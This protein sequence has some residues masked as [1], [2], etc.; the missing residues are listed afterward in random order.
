MFLGTESKF[1]LPGD[2]PGAPKEQLDFNSSGLGV[3]LNYDNRDNTMTPNKGHDIKFEY[4]NYNKAIGSDTDYDK[5][6]VASLSY[7]KLHPQVVLGVRLDAKTANGDTP[8][9]DLPYIDLRGIPALRYQ[10]ENVFVSEFDLRWDFTHRWSVVGFMGSGWT[11]DKISSFDDSDA[12]LAG[13]T[14]FRY[15]ISS[16][17]GLRAGLDIARGPEDTVVYFQVGSAW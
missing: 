3:L 12:R 13:G 11:A 16:K 17:L 2:I 8:F 5:I 14:G 9:Y 10:D 7:F 15:L 1:A 6:T 4:M